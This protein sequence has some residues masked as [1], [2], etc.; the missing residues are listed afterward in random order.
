MN[1][2]GRLFVNQA[3]CWAFMLHLIQGRLYEVDVIT[4]TLQTRKLKVDKFS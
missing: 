3:L 4:L 1:I 2:D